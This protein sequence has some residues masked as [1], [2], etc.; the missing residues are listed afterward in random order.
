MG[1]LSEFPAVLALAAAA[2]PALAGCGGGGDSELLPGATAS[3]IDSN[4]SQVE[5]LVEEG[6]CIGA[7]NSAAEVRS[8]VEALTG[9]DGKLKRA[10]AEGANRLSENVAAECV[11]PSEEEE[12]EVPT[13][14]PAEEAEP[15]EKAKEAKERAEEEHEGPT[16]PPQSNG[17][18]EENGEGKGPPEEHGQGHGPPEETVA[19][20]PPP[21]G[22]EPN[23]PAEGD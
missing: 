15:E 7:E 20:E 17:K 5:Q 11:E 21:G 19:P 22:I 8:Q 4:L 23:T 14:G 13:V 1:R 2:A 6:E 9:V 12:E 3:Q 10:L 16:L 18:G